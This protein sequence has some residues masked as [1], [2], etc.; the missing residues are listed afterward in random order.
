MRVNALLAWVDSTLRDPRSQRSS[1]ESV[2]ETERIGEQSVLA[3]PHPT[4]NFR[5]GICYVGGL[6]NETPLPW[7]KPEQGNRRASCD[8]TV[9]NLR[10]SKRAS[11][12]IGR[13]WGPRLLKDDMAWAASIYP[14]YACSLF[15]I[16]LKRE[17]LAPWTQG[18][19]AQGPWAA[20]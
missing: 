17:S 18:T 10:A 14:S 12:L 5:P 4:P 20:A 11:R 3:R 7:E 19:C 6:Q 13:I 8:L 1:A 15:S 2:R 16:G 9:G